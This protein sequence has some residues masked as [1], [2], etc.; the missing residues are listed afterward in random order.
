MCN[1]N[2]PFTSQDALEVVLVLKQQNNLNQLRTN[3]A[4]EKMMIDKVTK[5]F[6]P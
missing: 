5:I 1:D 2:P 6:G 3:S 4:E